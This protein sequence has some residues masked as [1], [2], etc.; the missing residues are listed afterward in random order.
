MTLKIEIVEEL[1]TAFGR[2]IEECPE[3][4]G[5][6]VGSA[7]FDPVIMVDTDADQDTEFEFPEGAFRGN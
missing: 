7:G 2:A 6:R 5:I 3:I 1:V 4:T